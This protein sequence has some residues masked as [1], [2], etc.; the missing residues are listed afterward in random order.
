MVA[1]GRACYLLIWLASAAGAQAPADDATL[2]HAIELHQSGDVEGAIGAYRE[3][4]KQAP[5][6]VMARSNLGAALARAGRYDEA[7]AEYERA[8][9]FQP[10]H[11][12]ACANLGSLLG[13]RGRYAEAEAALCRG[14]ERNP[15]SWELP[16]NLGHLLNKLGRIDEAVDCYRRAMSLWPES[17]RIHSSFLTVLQYCPQTTLAG[18]YEAHREFDRQHMARLRTLAKPLQ[19]TPDPDR[20]LRLGL[21]SPHLRQRRPWQKCSGFRT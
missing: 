21:I 9:R 8:I 14:L 20:P 12:L 7:I 19:I 4:L 5:S 3:Y 13:Q 11:A 6:N 15:R 1:C 16:N 18:L 17:A 2:R 10:D